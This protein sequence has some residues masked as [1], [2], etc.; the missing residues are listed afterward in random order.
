MDCKTFWDGNDS[1]AAKQNCSSIEDLQ[2]YFNLN[3]TSTEAN[4]KRIR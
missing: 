4:I 2:E 1:N 3:W